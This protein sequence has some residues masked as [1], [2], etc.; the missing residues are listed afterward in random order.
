MHLDEQQQT[1]EGKVSVSIY[2][3]NVNEDALI[4]V[5]LQDQQ[6]DDD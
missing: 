6:K 2:S 3:M 1:F 4:R 5:L